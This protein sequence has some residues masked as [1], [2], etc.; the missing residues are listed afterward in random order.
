[1]TKIFIIDDEDSVVRLLME[2]FNRLN[3]RCEG[4]FFDKDL[5]T[6]IREFMPD[7]IICDMNLQTTSGLE[8]LAQLKQNIDL[9]GISF[10]F[11]TGSINE[12]VIQ[13]GFELGADECL[14]KPLDL[15]EIKNQVCHVLNRKQGHA[16]NRLNILAIDQN[17]ERA[18]KLVKLLNG[19]LVDI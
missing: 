17:E 9:A 2:Y 5:L 11:L 16:Y 13:K 7:I 3:Y 14:R 18:D 19:F 10:V 12:D 15:S 1:M 4:Y 8:I 6:S